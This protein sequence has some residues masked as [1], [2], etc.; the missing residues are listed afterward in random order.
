M[1]LLSRYNNQ[2]FSSIAPTPI[3]SEKNTPRYSKSMPKGVITH[4]ESDP[5]YEHRKKV[6]SKENI[7]IYYAFSTSGNGFST[8][9]LFRS[10]MISN[11]RS[12]ARM[13]LPQAFE[14]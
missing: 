14:K 2:C 7:H 6:K 11:L 12:D 13:K 9:F 10:A 1:T 8:P 5:D 4:A 3:T